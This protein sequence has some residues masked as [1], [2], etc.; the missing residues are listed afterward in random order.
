M[1]YLMQFAIILGVSFAG[2]A[3]NMLL[4]LPVP[5]GV[6]GL[7]L[8]LLLLCTGVLKVEQVGGAARFLIE[9]MPVMFVPACVGLMDVYDRILPI[10][11]PFAIIILTSTVAVMAVTGRVTQRVIRLE[12]RE[13]H[14]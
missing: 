9:I 7:C 11:L 4:P 3:L 2:E 13:P 5:A 6:Y 14:A 8:M 1:S 10:L 12:R